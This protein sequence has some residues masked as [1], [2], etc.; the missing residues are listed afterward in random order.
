MENM[1]ETGTVIKVCLMWETGAQAIMPW[2]GVRDRHTNRGRIRLIT[3]CNK[4]RYQNSRFNDAPMGVIVS[5]THIAS[6]L[7][8]WHLP[9]R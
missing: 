3:S 8:F 7:E 4:L 1:C 6:I 2:D 5:Y 9:G